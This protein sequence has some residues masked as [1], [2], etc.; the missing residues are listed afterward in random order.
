MIDRY[1][2]LRTALVVVAAALFTPLACL[3]GCASR[4]LPLTSSEQ[5]LESAGRP[6]LR[7][8]SWMAPEAKGESLLYVSDTGMQ[9]VDVYAYPKGKLEGTLT[10]F[11]Y[12]A[13]ECVDQKSDVWIAD[14]SA[15]EVLE[16]AHAG[17]SPIASL[18]LA[19]QEPIDCSVD[20]TSGNLA[21]SN[22]VTTGGGAG[23]VSIFTKGSGAPA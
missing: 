18:T 1:S 21:V 12:P 16:Y 23:S 9:S 5:A 19:G 10:N 15:G 17:T 22:I 3:A 7:G 11:R 4:T 8:G 20:P 14:T 13:G 2:P 6:A